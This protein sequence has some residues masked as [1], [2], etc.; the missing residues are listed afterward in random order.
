MWSRVA[1]TSLIVSG[2]QCRGGAAGLLLFLLLYPPCPCDYTAESHPTVMKHSPHLGTWNLGTKDHGKG[3]AALG[4]GRDCRAKPAGTVWKDRF[5]LE[6]TSA[7]P[8][9]LPAGPPPAA[10]PPSAPGLPPPSVSAGTPV[11]PGTG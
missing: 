2:C 5:D 3:S 1:R 10:A 6:W 8:P 4:H 11:L 9:H 7:H